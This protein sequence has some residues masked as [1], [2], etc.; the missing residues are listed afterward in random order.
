[1]FAGMVV[2]YEPQ[3][4]DFK[5]ISDYCNW[6]DRFYILDNSKNN[7]YAGL[8]A[9][10]ANAEIDD[11]YNTKK[12]DGK[13][14]YYYFGKNLGVAT[15]VNFGMRRANR[16]GFQWAYLNDG[17]STVGTDVMEV[18][19]DYINNH[20]VSDVSMLAGVH[21]H[22]RSKEKSYKGTKEITWTM[23]SGCLYNTEMF[24]KS[25][26][27]K[28][29][30]F[31]DCVDLDYCY[32]MHEFGYRVVECGEAVL[33]HHPAETKELKVFGRTVLKYGY[34]SAWRYEMQCRGL[35]WV[36]LRYKHI[37]DLFM[38]FWKWFKV[39]FFFDNKTEY[40][41]QMIKGTRE[42]IFLYRKWKK[43]NK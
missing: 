30:L 23:G 3:E 42:G 6:F 26:G 21:I 4:S 20:D 9:A 25:G 8:C 41:R 35:I 7:N 11:V 36:L 29:S 14:Q 2:L 31:V 15:A 28:K 43:K 16:D 38:Y 33:I 10:I 37:N 18:F 17:D 5:Y 1:M 39:V 19:F 27:F 22:E 32:R 13:V 12:Y 34:A 40:F 24:C